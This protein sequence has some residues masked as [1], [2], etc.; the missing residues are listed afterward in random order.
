MKDKQSSKLFNLIETRKTIHTLSFSPLVLH[1]VI[2]L[3]CSNNVYWH[4]KLFME[5]IKV[6][7][8]AK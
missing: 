5:D 6:V 2:S 3:A 4:G 8:V 1:C 7:Y